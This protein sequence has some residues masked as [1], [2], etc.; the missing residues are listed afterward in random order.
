MRVYPFGGFSC[1]KIVRV[2]FAAIARFLI[3]LVF[4]AGALNKILH[5]HETERNL[6][7]TLCEWQ[8][9]LGFSD[10]GYECFAFLIPLTPLLLLVATLMEL[11]GGL[12]LL[13]GFKEKLGACLLA[14]FL[15]SVTI[16][17]HQFWFADEAMREQ[18]LA[19]FLKNLAILGG[20]IIVILQ[21]TNQN[22]SSPSFKL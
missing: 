18:Q 14:F 13:L 2:F 12:M 4:L 9:N 10:R 1:M 22:Q 5:W 3:S 16:I 19:H 15:V 20:L 21:G 7:A 11:C 17:M 6:H 8:S